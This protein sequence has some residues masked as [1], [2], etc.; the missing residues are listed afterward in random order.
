MAT[1]ARRQRAPYKGLDYQGRYEDDLTTD[2]DPLAAAAGILV[3]LL[4]TAAIVC[5]CFAVWL[6]M[7]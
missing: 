2:N 3:A 4:L 1:F 5:A 7:Q 6:V